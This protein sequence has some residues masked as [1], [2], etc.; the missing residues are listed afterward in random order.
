MN[1]L[2]SIIGTG[3]RFP[4]RVMH[5]T[6]IRELYRDEREWIRTRTEI[7]TRRIS[8]RSKGETTFSLSATAA[9]AGPENRPIFQG[10]DV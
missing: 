1:S 10:S 6:G 2:R 8:D 4:E 3:Y 7:E 9:E 5:N